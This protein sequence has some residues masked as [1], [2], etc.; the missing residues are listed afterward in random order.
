MVRTSQSFDKLEVQNE[1]QIA[2][3]SNLTK[4]G[5][6]DCR[7]DQSKQIIDLLEQLNKQQ[8]DNKHRKHMDSGSDNEQSGPQCVQQ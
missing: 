7:P 4:T 1:S 3:M 8:S 2:K 6:S 5:L